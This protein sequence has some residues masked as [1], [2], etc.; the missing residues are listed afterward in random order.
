M[1][2][3]DDEGKVTEHVI[4]DQ[5]SGNYG[6]EVPPGMWHMVISLEPGTIVYEV[7]DGPYVQANDKNFA[8]WAPR[9][10]AEDCDEYLQ[11]LI[12]KLDL[13]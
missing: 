5:S 8:K 10:G 11:K 7:K 1:V 13:K 6:V 3:F 9:E 4:L 12:T 2:F